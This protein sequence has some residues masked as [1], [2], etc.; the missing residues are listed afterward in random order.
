MDATTPTNPKKVN[1]E[2]LQLAECI[3]NVRALLIQILCDEIPAD[4]E[5]EGNAR[6]T[7]PT[8]NNVC[9]FIFEQMMLS[10][11]ATKRQQKFLMNVI[12]HFYLV[13]MHSIRRQ[14]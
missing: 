13:S 2:N 7:D 11:Q 8:N 9:T 14:R 4:I 1:A 10:L 12:R 6:N 5:I 3:G